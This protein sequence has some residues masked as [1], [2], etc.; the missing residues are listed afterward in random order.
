M[1]KKNLSKREEQI[2]LLLK[3]YDFLTRDQLNR[4]FKL[5]T[6]RNTNRILNEMSD[7]L[8]SIRDGYQSIYY[9][10]KEGREYVDCEKVRKKGGHVLHTVMRNQFW[11][12]YECP[13]D[14]DSEIKISDG[15]TEIIADAMFTKSLQR[16]FLEVDHT[17]PMKVNRAKIAKY[18]QLEKDGLIARELGHFPTI[19][20]LTATEMRRKQLQEACRELPVVKVYTF[21]DIK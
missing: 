10:S 4:Y 15:K 8:M 3:K 21:A 1:K 11:L 14:F 7:Y 13:S 20:W 9:L 16:H 12:Y 6:I 17:Q 19:V 5:G 18:I 2:L